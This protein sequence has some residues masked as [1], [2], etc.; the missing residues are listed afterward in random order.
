MPNSK[1]RKT[2][3]KESH[4][5]ITSEVDKDERQEDLFFPE[6]GQ[7]KVR[8]S[9][10]LSQVDV[11]W[12]VN[13]DTIEVVP[14]A[15]YL[16]AFR[17]FVSVQISH[18]GIRVRLNLPNLIIP[19]KLE[20]ATED[21]LRHLCL[22]LKDL[23][24]E[25]LDRATLA[26]FAI[27]L[28]LDVSKAAECF[29]NFYKL[30]NTNELKCPKLE[31]MKTMEDRGFIE[32]FACH[33]D[34]TFGHLCCPEKFEG[35][36]YEGTYIAREMLCYMMSMATLPLIRKG[37]TGVV[38]GRNVTWKTFKPIGIAKFFNMLNPCIPLKFVERFV[39]DPCNYSKLANT[40]CKHIL[41]QDY[42]NTLLRLDEIR[43]LYPHVVLPKS[44]T[45][46]PDNKLITH[47]S[48][49]EQMKFNFFLE[50]ST[51]H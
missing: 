25:I 27:G 1:R 14:S 12:D 20:E 26:L 21:A 13:E 41:P 2:T 45:G 17:S 40:V 22:L 30:A 33:L 31:I 18:P 36:K 5:C 48:A 37:L 28:D 46:L 24:F 9:D 6:L 43:K 44:L 34:G 3:D 16:P 35:E 51:L 8:C 7:G 10:I 50:N 29:L 38:N 47:L 15:E 42:S 32:G 19:L 49:D 11:K 39:V 4:A 23:G